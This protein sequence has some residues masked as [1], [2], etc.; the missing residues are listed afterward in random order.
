MKKNVVSRARAKGLAVLLSLG[1]LASSMPAALSEGKAKKPKLSTAKVTVTVGKTKKVK[2]KNAAKVT[3]RLSK[4]AKKIV[5]LSKKTKKGATI[6]GLKKGTARI[7]VVMKAGKK[8]YKKTIKVTVKAK[9]S[10][11][12]PA[13][14]KQSARPTVPVAANPNGGVPT[15]TPTAEATPTPTPTEKPT[16]TPIET[17][18]PTEAPN[19]PTAAP[20]MI[21]LPEPGENDMAIDIS[22]ENEYGMNSVAD[23]SIVYHEGYGVTYTSTGANSGGGIAYWIHDDQKGADLTK[24]KAIRIIASSS[25]DNAPVVCE[26][27]KNNPANVWNGSIDVFDGYTEYTSLATAGTPQVLEFQI[28]EEMAKALDEDT[29]AYGIR[30]KYNA[31]HGADEEDFDDCEFTIYSIMLIGREEAEEPDI[32]ETPGPASGSA[33]VVVAA[34]GGAA[35]AE[36]KKGDTLALQANV[37]VSGCAVSGD[38]Q[39]ES[40]NESVAAVTATGQAAVVTAVGAGEATIKATIT[41]DTGIT[42]SGKY[43]LTVKQDE[44]VLEGD[45]LGAGASYTYVANGAAAYTSVGIFAIDKTKLSADVPITLTWTAENSKGVDVKDSQ[46]LNIGL[47]TGNMWNSPAI[48]DVYGRTGGSTEVAL[49]AEEIAKAGEEDTVYMHVS[50]STAGFDGTVRITGVMAGEESIV[51]TLPDAYTYVENGLAQYAKTASVSLPAGFD[52]SLYTTCKIEFT[53]S[54]PDFEFHGIVGHKVNGAEITDP[55]Y[56]A[57]NGMFEITLNKVLADQG[58]DPFIVINAG[59]AGYKGSVEITKITFLP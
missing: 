41:T 55:Q 18:E 44:L 27:I 11:S 25:M 38:I 49:T 21:P 15:S 13:E 5:K 58:T 3:W 54:D 1:L 47:K 42:A 48:K 50:L 2:V 9:K 22:K 28:S 8:T 46:G 53:A 16:A 14:N 37:T 30:L 56:G 4:K 26:L 59:K 35:T 34:S 12:Q 36:L 52:F 51:E 45:A 33:A 43:D 29:L 23:G 39:W 57:Q 32:P 40:S 20:T 24:F 31:Y 17:A 19:E 7:S 10:Q 6:K